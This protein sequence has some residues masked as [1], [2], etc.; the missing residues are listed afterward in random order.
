M[1]PININQKALHIL[2]KLR[3]SGHKAYLVGGCVRDSIL[4]RPIKDWD[5]ATNAK[6]DEIKQLFDKVIPT[7][8][9]HGTIAVI[10]DKEAFEVTTFRKDGIYIDNR[11]PNDVIFVE[12]LK[13]DLARR[14]FTMNAIAYNPDEGYVDYFGGFSDILQKRISSV[15]T[16]A[17]RIREDPLRMMRAIRFMAQLSFIINGDLSDAITNKYYLINA[18]SKER[19]RDELDKILVS[20][21]SYLGVKYLITNKL[22]GSIFPELMESRNFN[23]CNK[24]H[25]LDALAHALETLK[26]INKGN[27]PLS[28]AA[29]L[30]DVAKPYTFTRGEDGDGHFYGHAIVGSKMATNMLKRMKYS[31]ETIN[32]VS[33]LIKWHL[34]SS[35]GFAKNGHSKMFDEVKIDN[36]PL[37]FDLMRADRLSHRDPDLSDIMELRDKTTEYLS[38]NNLVDELKIDL[39]GFDLMDLGIPQGRYIGL[40]LKE[41]TDMVLS[42]A[43]ENKKENLIEVAMKIYSR[44]FGQLL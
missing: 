5:I 2:E 34:P 44:I 15:G 11:R 27:L 8:E 30:H 29:L 20:D 14:D 3:D 23:Q 7:G 42:G 22:M 19:I 43:L 26:N 24:H 38:N 13:D 1:E 6:S 37:L 12:E 39:T 9:K 4:K 33:M 35:V 40:I 16:P 10:V 25:Y 32:L 28:L 41:L 36:L 31:N 17:D 21:N 18:I